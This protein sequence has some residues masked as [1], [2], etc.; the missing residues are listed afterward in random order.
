M[1]INKKIIVPVLSTVM[2]LSLIGGV[3]G[4][5]AWYQYN[6]R[7]TTSFVGVASA[8]S[9]LLQISADGSTW[10]KDLGLTPEK[11]LIPVTFG[12]TMTAN[13]A[14]PA[15]AYSTPEAGA[16]NYT[17]KKWQTAVANKDFVQYDIYLQA[18]QL[19]NANGQMERVAR[20]VY[21]SDIVMNATAATTTAGK[22]EIVDALR[23]HLAVDGGSNFFISKG[24]VSEMALSGY[25]DLDGDGEDDVES[26]ITE[27]DPLVIRVNYSI[28]EYN[29][30]FYIEYYK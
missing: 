10:K 21:L 5:V 30:F 7:V 17:T 2:G 22:A 15:N 27:D 29:V 19:N 24:T 14:L 18:L 8:N 26:P 11:N 6:S 9:G 3:S 1:K 20:D 12:E 16:G 13:S 25:L 28:K 4:A 23:L